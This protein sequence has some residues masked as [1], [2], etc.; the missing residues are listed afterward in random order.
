MVRAWY[1]DSENTD[2]RFEHHR[3]PSKFLELGELWK[4]TGV[5]YFAV[6]CNQII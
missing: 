3:N 2:Q 1:M 6:N 4:K 5:E